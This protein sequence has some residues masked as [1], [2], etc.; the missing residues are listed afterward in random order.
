MT[1]RA[2]WDAWA[3]TGKKYENPVDAEE[4][5]LHIAHTLGWTEQT[6]V[7]TKID[8]PPVS[9]TADEDDI[10]DN[11]EETKSRS[12]GG[13]GLIVSSLAAPPPVF[14]SSVHGLAL[15]NDVSGLTALLERSPDTDLN[16]LD[17]YVSTL[18]TVLFAFD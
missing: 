11:D 2:K 4:R 15:S 9:S 18:F 14:D 13:M 6:I 1:G 10:W 12:G 7:E 8:V 17:E 5:Y 3:A 16:A